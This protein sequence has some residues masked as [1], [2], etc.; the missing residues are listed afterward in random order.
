MQERPPQQSQ[1]ALEHP[2]RGRGGREP[3]PRGGRGTQRGSLHTCPTVCSGWMFRSVQKRKRKA[4]RVLNGRPLPHGAQRQNNYRSSRSGMKRSLL[5]AKGGDPQVPGGPSCSFSS[6]GSAESEKPPK[7]R[8][9]TLDQSPPPCSWG[10]ANPRAE[11]RAEDGDLGSVLSQKLDRLSENMSTICRDVSQLQSHMDR[12]E[13]DAR[14]WVLELAALRMEN[15]CLSE[16]VRR[17]ESRCRT[18]ENRSRRNNLRLLGLPEGVEGSDTVSFLQKTL[19]A[20][21]G[22]QPDSRPLEIESARRVQGGVS[23]EPNGRPR[24]LVFR[25]LHFAD[26]A[27]ILQASRTRPLCYAGAQVTI[28]PDFCSSPSQRRRVPFRTFRRARWAADVCFAARRSP[29]FAW[30]RGLREPLASSGPPAGRPGFLQ[31]QATGT[32]IP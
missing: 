8:C 29:C 5:T 20:M 19:P 9:P 2:A 16:Y 26:K 27:A 25:L 12:L 32:Q 15:Q 13:Q 23:W 28:L 6:G 7:K 31:G 22:L 18:L 10:K 3:S 1:H 4:R 17:M 30:S 14:G 21:L 24:A 11:C